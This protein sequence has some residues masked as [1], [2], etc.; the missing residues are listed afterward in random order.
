MDSNITFMFRTNWCVCG[1]QLCGAVAVQTSPVF[2]VEL[3]VLLGANIGVPGASMREQANN[4]EVPTISNLK[5]RKID[6]FAQ[7]EQFGSKVR[8]VPIVF[9]EPMP[10]PASQVTRSFDR[11]ISVKKYLLHDGARVGRWVRWRA[12]YYRLPT[13]CRPG[14]SAP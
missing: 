1:C 3:Q 12:G 5:G 9:V 7:P 4:S 14:R 13:R 8:D 2:A 6:G 10:G 11:N